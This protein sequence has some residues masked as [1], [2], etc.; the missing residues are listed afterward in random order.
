[1]SKSLE[2]KM[3]SEKKLYL[4]STNKKI[5]GVCGGIAEYLGIDPTIIRILWV[6]F[7][8]AVG[9]GILAYIIAWMLMSNKPPD[10]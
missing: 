8:F 7:A 4:S 1:M 3:E 2:G 5:G 9:S 10:Y 6:I